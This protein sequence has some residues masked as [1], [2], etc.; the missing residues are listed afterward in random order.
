MGKEAVPHKLWTGIAVRCLSSW[1]CTETVF[2]WSACTPK[3]ELTTL[4][5]TP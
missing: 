4:P 1:K 2:S 5:Q 3:G